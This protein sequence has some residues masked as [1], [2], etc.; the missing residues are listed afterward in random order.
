MGSLDGLTGR[1]SI[2]WHRKAATPFD[3][4]GSTRDAGRF[5]PA[6]VGWYCEHFTL[7][8][9]SPR[10]WRVRYAPGVICAGGR[11]N[12][13]HMA[14]PRSS[15]SSGGTILKAAAASLAAGSIQIETAGGR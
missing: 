9:A 6:G 3:P 7:V 14:I 15:A 2:R 4:Q 8:D 5:L 1:T 13:Q 10:N 11:N 12:G